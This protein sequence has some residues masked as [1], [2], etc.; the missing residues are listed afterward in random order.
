VAK[1]LKLDVLWDLNIKKGRVDHAWIKDGYAMVAAQGPN[2]LYMMRQRDGMNIWNCEFGAPVETAYP[3]SVSADAVMVVSDSKIVRVHRTH[4]QIICLLNPELPISASPV[5]STWAETEGGE[6]A[7]YVPSYGDGRLWSLRIRKILREI[8]SP[9]PG[10]PPVNIPVYAT[11]RGWNRAAPQGRGQILAPL[12]YS[13]GFIYVCT[14]NG[15]VMAVKDTTGAPV[16]RIETQGAVESGVCLSKNRL[17]VGST[18]YKLYC[19]DRFSGEKLWDLPTG[20]SVV[21]RPLADPRGELVVCLSEGQGL[22]GVNVASGKKLW[23]NM[24]AAQILGM[25][26][27]TVYALSKSGALLGIDMK[28]GQTAWENRDT[29]FVKIFPTTEQYEADGRLLH[30]LALT[31]ANDIVCLVEPGHSARVAG[32]K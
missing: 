11:T 6:A 25:G 1:G 2:L 9:V 18:D 8:P 16:W 21:P 23:A 3:P 15:Y 28:T 7:I 22:L 12:S 29:G 19:L 14:T 5:L 4:G 24:D 30:L 17:F 26:E 31:K 10:E 32:G 20:G 27:S 13:D